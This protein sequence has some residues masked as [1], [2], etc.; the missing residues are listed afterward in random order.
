MKEPA[1]LSQIWETL[2][3]DMSS[4]KQDIPSNLDMFQHIL[5]DPVG[6]RDK[7]IKLLISLCGTK[8]EGDYSIR[9]IEFL[10]DFTI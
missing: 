8:N 7:F 4:L 3:R 10:R 5:M 6:Q 2:A 9:L 1:I